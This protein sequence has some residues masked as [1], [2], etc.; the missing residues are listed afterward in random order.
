MAESY[1]ICLDV[2]GTK[3]LGAIFNEK[4]E[5]IYRLKKRSKS[6][7][8]GSADV[9]KVIISVVEEMIKKS[10]IDPKKLN[11]IASCAPGVIDQDRG[12]VLFTPNLPWRNYDIAGAM[13]KKFGVPFFVGNDVNLGVLGEYKFGAAKGYKN[14]VGFFPGTGMGGGLILDGKLF[15]GN[16]FKAAEY[17]H[18][19]LDPDGP[20]CGCGQSGCLEVFSSKRGMSDY[21]RQ[22]VGRKRPC[23]LAED[24]ANGGIF[25]SKRLKKALA[26]KDEVAMEAVDRACHYLAIATGNMINTIS[27]DLVIYGGGIMEAMGPLFLEKILKELDR[28]CMISIRPTVDV[29]LAALGDDSILYGD[30]ALIKGL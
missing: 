12:I 23:M 2:G 10:G 6:E 24:V 19:T 16:Q 26:A 27:P 21:I 14:I 18:M 13:K 17:G 28:Y 20:L 25:R 8:E 5:I 29:K 22:Q 4:D 1:N 9:E 3:V 11:A 15:T 7:G 30:L